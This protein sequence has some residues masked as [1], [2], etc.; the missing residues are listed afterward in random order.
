MAK[1]SE[2][3][4]AARLDDPRLEGIVPWAPGVHRQYPVRGLRGST[5]SWVESPDGTLRKETYMVDAEDWQYLN[6][7][8][9]N[10]LLLG[11]HTRDQIELWSAE[12]KAYR[13]SQ[14]QDSR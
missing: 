6:E 12:L 11:F 3:D 7:K 8:Y 14:T 5:G 1:L 10:Q 4:A 9:G 13:S 2:G